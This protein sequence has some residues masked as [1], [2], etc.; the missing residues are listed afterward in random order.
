M[1]VFAEASFD[2]VETA[3]AAIARGEFVVV[4]DDTDRENEG[5]LIVAADAITPAQMAFLVRHSSGLVCVALPGERLDALAL[6][7]MVEANSESQQ[8]AFTV[9]VDYR[10]GTSTGISAADRAATLNA[11]ADPSSRPDDFARPGHIFPLRARAGGVLERPGHTEAALDLAV[12]AGHRPAGVLCEIVNDDGSMARRPELFAFAREHGLPIVSIEQLI[13][14]RRAR[15]VAPAPQL[16]AETRLPTRHGEFR[17]HL[18][19]FEGGEYPVLLAGEPAGEGLLTR[20]HS[21]CLTG[22]VLGSLRCDC[23]EQLDL[24]LARIAREGRGALLYLT[25]HEGRGIGLAAKLRAYALQD[26]GLDTVEA[27]RALGLPV[28][29]RDYRAAAAILGHLGVRSVQLLSNNPTKARA[30]Q[31]AGIAVQ[32]QLA[33]EVPANP[34]NQHYLATKRERLGHRLVLPVV[35]QGRA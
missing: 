33:H 12:L 5:D 35:V 6:P 25:G 21:E 1:P 18:Y 13:A 22:D 15:E 8:T 24:A 10:H 19:A 32:R 7:L 31:E 27:N 28:E 3:I 23:G 20:L 30:L 14:W 11:L 4:V 2:T 26:G 16:L 29:A 9:S 34:A 17:L